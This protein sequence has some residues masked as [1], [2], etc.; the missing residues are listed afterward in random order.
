MCVRSIRSSDDDAYVSVDMSQLHIATPFQDFNLKRSV[1]TSVHFSVF[2]KLCVCVREREREEGVLRTSHN[3]RSS[4]ISIFFEFE[5][6]L[7]ERDVDSIDDHRNESDFSSLCTQ[8][9]SSNE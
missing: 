1:F 6:V 3:E 2:G 5:R 8:S 7:I 4:K 9:H